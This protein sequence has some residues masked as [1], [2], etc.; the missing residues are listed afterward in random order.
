MTT[1][2]DA[3]PK[4]HLKAYDLKGLPRVVTIKRFEMK[5]LWDR[6]EGCNKP[7]PVLHFEGVPKYLILIPTTWEKIAE[8]LDEPMAEKWVGKC[9]ELYP[10]KERHAGELWDVIR[11]R[12][13]SQ[14][15]QTPQQP[16]APPDV[17]Q[18]KEI[19]PKQYRALVDRL[20]IPDEEALAI[21][22][23]CGKDYSK[24]YAYLEK[25]YAELLEF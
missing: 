19:G 6:K 8:I 12:K 10:N 18:A 16:A 5:P 21:Y 11:V 22:K 9:I 17:R 24:A 23:E 20:G 14:P 2:H 25:E 4:P 15:M 7:K 3:F 1:I 13:P